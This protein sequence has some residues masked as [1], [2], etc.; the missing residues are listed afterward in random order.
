M[1]I[2]GIVKKVELDQSKKVYIEV[3]LSRILAVCFDG[4]SLIED[5]QPYYNNN[6]HKYGLNTEFLLKA[7]ENFKNLYKYNIVGF[8]RKHDV[9]LFFKQ[10]YDNKLAYL[11]DE[12]DSLLKTDSIV[13]CLIVRN[14][15]QE[16]KY[17]SDHLK[18]NEFIQLSLKNSL[19]KGAKQ[20]FLADYLIQL[21][22]P[23]ILGNY[24]LK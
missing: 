11:N 7:Y 18:N 22:I 4:E 14:K 6:S 12:I 13:N 23:L 1:I 9:R 19:I 8:I 10:I 21:Q 15:L 5:S 2:E 3:R 24:L 20:H 16:S 17:K